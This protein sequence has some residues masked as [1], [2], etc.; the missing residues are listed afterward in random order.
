MG[1]V[2]YPS[3][4]TDAEWTLIEPLLPLSTRKRRPA[5]HSRRAIMNGIFYILRSG[6]AWRMM[7]HDLPPWKTVYDYFWKW[8]RTGVISRIHELFRKQVRIRA[9]RNPEPSAAIVDSQSVKTTEVGGERGYDAGKKVTGRKRH[10][11]VDTLGLLLEVVVHPANI[12]DRDGAKLVFNKALGRFDRFQRI[13]ADGGYAGQLVN[14]VKEKSM[15]VLDIV[16]RSEDQRRFEVLPRRWVVERTFGWLGRSRR[17]SKDYERLTDTSEAMIQLAMT[18][19]ML[20][21]LA[22][23]P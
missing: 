14:W 10:I 22:S 3:D 4:V 19:L 9:G 20:K 17:L 7:P 2:C 12:Q 1:D 18:R 8:R 11:L 15:W 6:C 5:K 21:R 23:P 13:W 16:R